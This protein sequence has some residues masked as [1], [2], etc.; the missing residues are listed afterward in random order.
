MI[1]QGAFSALH[2]ICEDCSD[3]FHAESL[4]NTLEVLIPKF[5]QFFGHSSPTIKS[6]AIACVN[7]FVINQPPALV[8]NILPFIQVCAMFVIVVCVSLLIHFASCQQGLFEA[9]GDD[10]VDVKKNVCRALVMLLEVRAT[11]LLSHMQPI[12][13]VSHSQL[14]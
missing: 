1:W 6:H 3:Q 9:S 5:I 13:E 11:D 12:I 8:A 10:S 14:K 2:K 7:Q 4:G